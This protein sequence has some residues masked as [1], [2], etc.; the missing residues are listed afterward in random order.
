M[1]PGY[2]LFIPRVDCR[3]PRKLCLK[4]SHT[5]FGEEP[6]SDVSPATSKRL[7]LCHRPSCNCQR[8]VT[9]GTLHHHA[10]ELR[11]HRQSV[12]SRTCN[13]YEDEV[14]VYSGKYRRRR[15]IA[16]PLEQHFQAT[17]VPRQQGGRKR[18]AMR[19]CKY[20]VDIFPEPQFPLCVPP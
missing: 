10:N 12:S 16:H 11:A 17:V 4:G 9:H 1:V 13:Q 2:D 8:F 5:Q 3:R 19:L 20:L 15:K 18:Q 14:I 6:H 7:C